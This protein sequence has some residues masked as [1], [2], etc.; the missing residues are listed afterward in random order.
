MPIGDLLAQ[1]SGEPS[2]TLSSPPVGLVRKADN[3]I[4]KP[5]PSVQKAKTSLE[6]SSAQVPP[7]KKNQMSHSYNSNS[8]VKLAPSTNQRPGQT[9]Y[10][11]PTPKAAPPAAPATST[12]TSSSKPPKK[13]SFA[14]IMAR[15]KAAQANLGAVGKI[16]HKK[17]EKRERE[18][19]KGRRIQKLGK[20]LASDKANGKLGQMPLKDG[21]NG[22][23]EHSGKIG[24]VS[25]SSEKD[26]GQP[27]K[28]IKKAAL[29]TTGYTGTARP[30]P[31]GA[32][33]G[34]ASS[35]RSTMN[36]HRSHG[37]G[38]TSSSKRHYESEEDEDED[39][40][41]DEEEEEDYYSDVSS[42][43]EAAIFEVDEEEAYA[44]RIARQE[45]AEALREEMRLKREKLEK[46]KRLMAMAKKARR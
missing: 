42:D 36:G 25:K 40:E 10:V 34:A 5:S 4:R 17:I 29:A 33:L 39:E 44:E 12:T 16:Q 28:K 20:T 9:K 21:R 23:Q 26:K 14:E 11:P 24:V 27:E 37:Y 43:M 3:D 30:K 41:E 38:G 18:D 35:S 2:P 22:A 46:K 6:N 31:G 13:G 15:A 7:T 19:I 8:A 32:R 45:D 1:I